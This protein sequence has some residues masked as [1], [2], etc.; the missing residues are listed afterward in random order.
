[1]YV[2]MYACMYVCMYRRI[3]A[4]FR[5]YEASMC[6]KFLRDHMHLGLEDLRLG[7]G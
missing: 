5:M 6:I 1:M 2:C 7:K 4:P 3:G